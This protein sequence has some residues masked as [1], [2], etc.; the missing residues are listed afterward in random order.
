MR[1]MLPALRDQSGWGQNKT[2]FELV[3][4]DLSAADD[5]EPGVGR[6]VVLGAACPRRRVGVA[7]P[8]LVVLVVAVVVVSG[9]AWRGRRRSSRVRHHRHVVTVSSLASHCQST[10]SAYRKKDLESSVSGMVFFSLVHFSCSPL[11][12][13]FKD[14][15]PVKIGRPI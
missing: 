14:H 4:R 11:L 13:T 5:E 12:S 10:G 2:L 9:P 6:V 3:F 15:Q 1:Q 7:A 8:H